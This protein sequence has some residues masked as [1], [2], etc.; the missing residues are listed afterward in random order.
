M[1]EPR[2][3][4]PPCGAMTAHCFRLYPG[5]KLMPSL[6]QAAAV[7]LSSS[8]RESAFIVTAVGSLERATIRLAN[9]SRTGGNDTGGNDIKTYIQRFEIV[10]LVGTFSA[11]GSGCQCHLHISLSDA[12]GNTIGGHLMDGTVFTTCE[13]VMG[14]ADNVKFTRIMDDDTGYNE[15]EVSQILPKQQSQQSHLGK[16]IPAALTLLAACFIAGRLKGR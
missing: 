8:K 9:A 15:L 10:S 5:E 1:P 4:V 2:L 13:I 14:T 12:E 16:A 11:A 3:I 7:I 6:K